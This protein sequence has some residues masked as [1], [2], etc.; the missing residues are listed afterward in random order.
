MSVKQSPPDGSHRPLLEKAIP[1]SQ[2]SSGPMLESMRGDHND[3]R[4]ERAD[5]FNI[6]ADVVWLNDIDDFDDVLIVV[7]AEG[8]GRL[9]SCGRAAGVRVFGLADGAGASY[10]SGECSVH[11]VAKVAPRRNVPP[12]R[13]AN[14]REFMI[15]AF[16]KGGHLRPGCEAGRLLGRTPGGLASPADV[17]LL[18]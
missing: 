14:L 6:V 5:H 4:I 16:E 13:C 1:C 7:P 12:L 11:E 3:L 18:K 2:R 10:C 17:G 15:E 9:T 8:K